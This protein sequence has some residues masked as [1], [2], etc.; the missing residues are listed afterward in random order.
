MT[1]TELGLSNLAIRERSFGRVR[2]VD[3]VEV[4][5]VL[6]AVLMFACLPL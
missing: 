6:L 1:A 3:E 2:G 5:A 4:A